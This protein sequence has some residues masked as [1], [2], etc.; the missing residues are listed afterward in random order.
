MPDA[1]AVYVQKLPQQPN[2]LALHA[3]FPVRYP[4]LLESAAAHPLTGRYDIL[5]AFP[6]TLI[7][8]REQGADFLRELADA[9]RLTPVATDDHGLPF[10]GGWITYLGYELAGAIEPRLRLPQPADSSLPMALAWRCPA[11]LIHDRLRGESWAV[12]EREPDLQRLVA[13][14]SQAATP[15]TTLP[16]YRL[17]EQD[18]VRHLAAIA[19][20]QDYIRAGDIFQANLSRRWQADFA[21]PIAPEAVYA[22]LRR[23]NP[24]PYAASLR[25]GDAAVLSSS[26]ERLLQA[27]AGW[28]QT[29]PIAGTRGRASDPT[30]DEALARELL[31]HPKERAEHVMLV[32]LERNDL[33]RI[34][35]PGSVRVS[36]QLQVETYA[37]VHH[38]VSAVEGKLRAGVDVAA[39]L[40]ALF[41]GGTITGC[42]KV[43]CMEIIAELEGEAR[44]PYTGSIGY[45]SRNGR[46]DFNILIRTALLEGCQLSFRAGGGI[47]ADSDPARELAETRVKAKGILRALEA[48]SC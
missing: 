24:A 3:S 5:P 22:R 35:Q 18:S 32:D 8:A 21:A 14:L 2:L 34:C 29:R 10:V 47:V 43:R 25:W 17:S 37:H 41:P 6:E 38:I 48:T 4:L 39:I 44:G 23:T 16:A 20:A 30:E 1:T 7:V 13:D 46:M 27:K 28:V 19:R 36:E 9:C 31:A 45:V 42:P 12:A 26:P 33:G 11:A 40:A 15:K